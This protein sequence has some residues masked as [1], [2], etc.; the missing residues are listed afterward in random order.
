MPNRLVQ[1]DVQKQLDEQ[2][3]ELMAE[4]KEYF[5]EVFEKSFDKLSGD[6]DK[7]IRNYEVKASE[8]L[9]NIEGIIVT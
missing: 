8:G 2:N 7:K 4:L 5:S 1:V 3:A 6:V 9:K